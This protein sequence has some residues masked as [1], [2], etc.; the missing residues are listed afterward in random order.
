MANK[1]LLP[2]AAFL[3]V[4]SGK[5]IAAEP[6]KPS[7]ISQI[8]QQ[9]AAP[10]IVNQVPALL[11]APVET[12]LSSPMFG[13][14]AKHNVSLGSSFKKGELLISF[15]CADRDA[16]VDMGEA[17]FAAAQIAYENKL[18]LQGLS[19]AGEIEVTLAATEA[20]RTKAQLVYYE[21]LAE[22]CDVRAPFSGKVANV[23]VNPHQGVAQ[24][25]P[26]VDIVSTNGL[27]ALMNIPASWLQDVKIKDEISLSINETGKT[28]AAKLSAINSTVD[29]VSHTIEV[30]AEITKAPSNLL[31][32]MSGSAQ[33]LR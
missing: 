16:Q 7:I 17:E 15:V 12:T 1:A 32:G 10:M 20:S 6:E 33:F 5:L 3:S 24:G 11:I 8:E 22:Q 2:V 14:V 30:E 21:A 28:Y 23:R 4:L 19:Q 18:K 29:S 9:V 26:L 13:R 25:E 27:K 31:P